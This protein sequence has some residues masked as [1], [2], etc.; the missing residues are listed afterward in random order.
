MNY[1]SRMKQLLKIILILFDS[2]P[3]QHTDKQ[4]CFL[5]LWF[6]CELKI[7][8]GNEKHKTKSPTNSQFLTELSKT[9]YRV[10]FFQKREKNLCQKH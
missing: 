5:M 4:T 10:F 8:T 9:K 7:E 3:S 2:P 6:N 1:V